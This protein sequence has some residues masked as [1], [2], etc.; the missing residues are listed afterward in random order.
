MKRKDSCNLIHKGDKRD[1]LVYP[2]LGQDRMATA[3]N[4]AVTMVPENEK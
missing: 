3:G 4:K 2:E 1:A